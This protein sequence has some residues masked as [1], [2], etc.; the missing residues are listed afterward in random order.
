MEL[1]LTGG[2]EK[3]IAWRKGIGCNVDG[4]KEGGK[5]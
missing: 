2:D 4:S 3:K 5:S 1:R